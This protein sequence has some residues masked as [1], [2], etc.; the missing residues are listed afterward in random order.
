MF[1]VLVGDPNLPDGLELVTAG[2]GPP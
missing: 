1:D 2:R